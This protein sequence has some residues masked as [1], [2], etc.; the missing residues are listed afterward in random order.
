MQPFC[1]QM[2][3]ANILQD[4]PELASVRLLVEMMDYLELHRTCVY[5]FVVY[6]ARRRHLQE[7]MHRIQSRH[8][9]PII[10]V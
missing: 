5:S 4:S 2:Y 8:I 7:A 10:R 9:G 1:M 6:I 3:R